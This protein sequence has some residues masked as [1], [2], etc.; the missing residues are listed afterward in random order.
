MKTV[1]FGWSSG[2]PSIRS[3]CSPS[4]ARPNQRIQPTAFGA[5]DRCLCPVASYIVGLIAIG[6]SQPR[7]DILA[8]APVLEP[9]RRDA[10]VTL[11]AVHPAAS[12]E[13]DREVLTRRAR[14]RFRATDR[15]LLALK[16]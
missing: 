3:H 8:V 16:H 1:A 13:A 11:S 14:S 12:C 10:G 15:G 6:T 7:D 2:V 4:V 5:R 9:W